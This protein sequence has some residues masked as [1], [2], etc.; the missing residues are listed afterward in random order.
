MAQRQEGSKQRENDHFSYIVENDGSGRKTDNGEKYKRW[1]GNIAMEAEM[2]GGK[3]AS[4]KMKRIEM[5]R[6][7]LT[8]NRM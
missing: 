2:K 7:K 3:R 1:K 6:D 5:E 4:I 8:Y